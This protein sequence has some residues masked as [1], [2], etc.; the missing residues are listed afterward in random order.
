MSALRRE[1]MLQK[2]FEIQ[3]QEANKLNAKAADYA[4]LKREAESNRQ[5]YDNLL[6]KLKEA[7]L[8]AGLRSGNIRVYDPA[9]PAKFPSEPN[10]PRNLAI[11]FVVGL[12]LRIGLAFSLE[13]M[14]NTLRSSEE[15]ESVSAFPVIGIVPLGKTNRTNMR[16]SPALKSLTQDSNTNGSGHGPVEIISQSRPRSEIAEAYRSLRTSIL[17]SSAGH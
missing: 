12:S 4:I 6:Q 11:A 5:L 7:G 1:Q 17:L 8:S 15:V 16:R 10:I 14:D 9:R 3:K 13:A 2:S